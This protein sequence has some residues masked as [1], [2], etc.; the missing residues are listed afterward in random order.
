GDEELFGG[1]FGGAMMVRGRCSIKVWKSLRRV[2]LSAN[3]GR[4]SCGRRL[5][6]HQP[7]HT[8]QVVRRCHE[9]R[10]QLGARESTVARPTEATDGFQP[11]EYLLNPFSQTLTDGVPRMA[12][13]ATVNRASPSIGVL[14][15]MRRDTVLAHG[16]HAGACVIRLV[17]PER[18][19]VKSR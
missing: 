18:T 11:A 17:S 14:G 9:I 7:S 19:W 5:G 15:H 12:C 6:R 3:L 16:R 4:R 10:G 2:S 1:R 13:G 8:H